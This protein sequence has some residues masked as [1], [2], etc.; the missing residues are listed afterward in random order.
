M[1]ALAPFPR[2]RYSFAGW[3]VG[4]PIALP[5]VWALSVSISSG[6]DIWGLAFAGLITL[7][8]LGRSVLWGSAL[9]RPVFWYENE[10]LVV[11]KGRRTVLNAPLCTIEAAHLLP[12][13]GSLL[14][15]PNH[16]NS[17]LLLRVKGVDQE[18]VLL[19]PTDRYEREFWA[20]WTLTTL[21]RLRSL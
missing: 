9:F 12:R 5:G 19:A 21:P 17:T 18:I 4:I 14:F 8:G 6:W 10:T 1:S 2:K 13:R 3:L 15:S 20:A 16:D 11:N 7:A